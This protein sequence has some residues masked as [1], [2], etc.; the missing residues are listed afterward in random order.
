V[1]IGKD[2]TGVLKHVSP[3]KYKIVVAGI[4]GD[5]YLIAALMGSTDVLANGLDL[6]NGVAG[7]LELTIGS[8]AARL[9]GTVK[10]DK[11]EL[12]KGVTVTVIAKDPK[13]RTDMTHSATTDQNGHFEFRGLVPAEYHVYAWG[14]IE[15]GAAEDEEFRKPFEKF[16][17][18]V[19]LTRGSLGSPLDLKLIPK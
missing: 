1:Q 13:S 17:A 19:D 18:D 14:D 5:N 16:R 4:P 11:D 7:S 9:S 10:N 12:A 15:P 8:P 6:R 3:D 2:G